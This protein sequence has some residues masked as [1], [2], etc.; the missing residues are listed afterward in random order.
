MLADARELP[1]G[2]LNISELVFVIITTL[3]EQDWW[4]NL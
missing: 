3:I 2:E 1:D 4:L